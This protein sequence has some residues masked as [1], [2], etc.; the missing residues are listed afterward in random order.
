M[1]KAVGLGAGGHAKVVLEALCL[2]NEY[3][4]VGLLDPARIGQAVHGVS[5]LGGDE[6]L[7]KL[8]AQGV[9]AVF[10]GI[11]GVKD[12]SARRDAYLRAVSAGFTAITVIHPS[13]IIA[14]SA[15]VE[16]GSVVLAG[17]IINPDARVGENTIINSGAI[18][19]HDCEIGAHVHVAPGSILSGG[20]R[21]GN[22]SYIGVGAVVREGIRIGEQ[23]MVAA[24]AVVVRNVP[25]R[26]VVAGVPA[27]LLSTEQAR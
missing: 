2:R 23:S 18:V 21:V 19:E 11:G 10:I 25:A 14:A 7:S 24:G 17:A 8:L 26:A 16:Q 4:I 5:V 9:S 3:D 15:Q 6:L 20:V 13:A 27:R 12:N 1:K 22:G